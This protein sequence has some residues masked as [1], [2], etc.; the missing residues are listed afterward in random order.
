MAWL[1]SSLIDPAGPFQVNVTWDGQLCRSAI[2][3]GAANDEKPAITAFIAKLA[4]HRGNNNKYIIYYC[5]RSLRILEDFE[6]GQPGLALGPFTLPYK[7]NLTQPF[8][9]LVSFTL[10]YLITHPSNQFIPRPPAI[11]FSLYPTLP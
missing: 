9:S 10:P 2:Q 5:A 7:K 1:K 3:I 4:I 11:P 6:S 8:E